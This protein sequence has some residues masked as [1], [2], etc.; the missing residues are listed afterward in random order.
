LWRIRNKQKEEG[1]VLLKKAVELE[2]DNTRFAYVYAASIGD[3]HPEEAIKI[4]EK[5]YAKHTGDIQVVTGLAYYYRIIGDERKS[6]E[7]E[8]KANAL[9]NFSVQ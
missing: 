1:I 3:E 7:Y 4:L 2:N 5:N 8:N 9:Q 6:V